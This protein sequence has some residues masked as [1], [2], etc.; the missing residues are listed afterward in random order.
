M[1]AITLKFSQ[2]IANQ[3]NLKVW[4]GLVVFMKLQNQVIYSQP[5]WE[6]S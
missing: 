2:N 5:L 3:N 1:H 4:K 6:Y